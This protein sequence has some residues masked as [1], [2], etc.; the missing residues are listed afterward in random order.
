MAVGLT[1]TIAYSTFEAVSA[2]ATAT[3]SASGTISAIT[4]SDGGF[5]YDVNATVEVLISTEPVT[6]ERIT[7]VECEGDYGIVVGVG[8]SA[9]GIN[10]TGPMVKFE[11]DADSFLNQAGFGNITRSGITAGKYF[12][13]YNG[14]VG[15]G[16]TSVYPGGGVIGVGTTFIDNW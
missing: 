15:N 13:I 4:L 10:T 5:G 16:L 7:S 9:T 1:S 3:V 2:A 6:K 12:V 11:L 8:T 14:R